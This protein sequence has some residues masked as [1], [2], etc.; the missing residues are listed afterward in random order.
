MSPETTLNPMDYRPLSPWAV[1][2]LTLAGISVAGFLIPTFSFLTLLSMMSAIVAVREDRNY[3]MGGRRIA[4]LGL[5]L[6]LTLGTILTVL[7]GFV[8]PAMKIE[9]FQAE[10]PLGTVRLDFEKVTSINEEED[11]LERYMGQRVCLKGY[12]LH[13]D[14]HEGIRSFALSTDGDARSTSSHVW[15]QLTAPLSFRWTPRGHAVTGTL[16]A[17]PEYIEGG[18]SSR[19]ILQQSEVRPVSSKDQLASYRG[20]GFGC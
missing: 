4:L 14:E 10:A 1:A 17:N 7:L 15:V 3:E 16:L 8:I 6:S 2:S 18:T 11:S 19:W 9:R 20:N 5:G 13:T 12:I